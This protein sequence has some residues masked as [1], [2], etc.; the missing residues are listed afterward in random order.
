[1][2]VYFRAGFIKNSV[3]AALLLGAMAAAIPSYAELI[4][5][6]KTVVQFHASDARW[7]SQ[8]NFSGV[9]RT[10]VHKD[11][12]VFATFLVDKTGR[13]HNISIAE[14]SGLRD[15]EKQK[16]KHALSRARLKPFIREGIA[17]NGQVTLSI[18]IASF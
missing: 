1:M 2:S 15:I 11:T 18:I 14:K 10:R 7:I 9:F 16:L 12:K 6:S 13:I 3:A 5:D 4:E 8:P 17:V